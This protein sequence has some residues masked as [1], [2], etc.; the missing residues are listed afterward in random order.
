MK[1]TR[2]DLLSWGGGLT[3]G[4]LVTPVPWKLLDDA[5]IWTQN[6]PWIPQPARGPVI[7]KPS[8][9]TLCPHG[10]GIR[11]RQAG[12]YPVGISGMPQHPVTRGALCPLAFAAHQLNWHPRRLRQVLHHGKAAS[13]TE[14]LEALRAANA[15]GPMAIMDGYPRRAASAIFESFARRHGGDYQTILTAE[16][17]SLEPYVAWTG[18]PVTSLGYDLEKVRTIVSFGAPLLDGWGTPGR[19]PRVWTDPQVH[20]IQIEA[21]LSRT[22]NSAWRWVPIAAGSEAA[23]AAGLAHVLIEE[24][25]GQ[26]PRPSITLAEA[27]GQ[28]G[29]DVD[30]LRELA[31]TIVA[32]GPALA[33]TADGSA[34]IAA[35]NVILGGN[36]IV[37]RWD[38]PSGVWKP[39]P[40]SCRA[41]LIDSTVPWEFAAPQAT[42]VFRFA[43]WDGGPTTA[44]WLLPAPGFLEALTDVPSAPA[45]AIETYA[46]APSLSPPPVEVHGLAECLKQIDPKLPKVEEVIHARCR[47]L[48]GEEA[49]RKGMVWTGDASRSRS[50]PIRFKRWPE[51]RNA[52][53]CGRAWTADWV[54]A[55]LPPLSAKLY[56]ESDLRE[57]PAGRQV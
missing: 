14:A 18:L 23:L 36:G 8:F 53:R 5:S 48:G 21:E 33:L 37:R 39:N 38:R 17:R 2:R 3:A 31:P 49:L 45:S 27:A 9:C 20:L 24:R 10:C 13:W 46:I 42:E 56:Q 22:G 32:H 28:T 50:V 19:F 35:L 6:W 29:L 55:V 51:P 26:G 4:L 43:A 15:E 7:T 57:P 41:V 25:L 30:A 1:I 44:D 11:V 34:A 40:G 54:P 52:P 16:Q 47:E 12:G